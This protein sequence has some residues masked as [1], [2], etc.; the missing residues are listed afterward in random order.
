VYER[1]PWLKYYGEISEHLDYNRETM[2]QALRKIAQHQPRAVAYDFLGTTG[3]YGE[4][5]KAVDRCAGALSAQGIACGDRVTVALP[6]TPH[7]V[8]LFYALNKLG[9]VAGMIHPLSAPSEVEFYLKISKSSWAVTL[10]AFYAKFREVL[11][12]TAVKRIFS[13]E[14]GRVLAHQRAQDRQCRRRSAGRLLEG[15]HVEPVLRGE[16]RPHGPGRVGRH[17]LFRRHYRHA[18]RHHAEQY[19]LQRAV[20]AASR[21]GT[22]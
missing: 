15:A 17:S 16:R 2:Y 9:A 14:T 6:N 7:A 1:K 22:P 18:Q 3:T 4:L 19:E 13:R 20:A 12:A 10:D 5:L 11:D 21:P 8:I